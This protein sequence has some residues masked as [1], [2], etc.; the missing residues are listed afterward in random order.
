MN[1]SIG[2]RD[3]HTASEILYVNNMFSTIDKVIDML[4]QKDIPFFKFIPNPCYKF[5]PYYHF[6]RD[7]RCAKCKLYFTE[8]ELF[9]VE[10]LGHVCPDC[11]CASQDIDRCP[12]CGEAY[13]ISK[14]HKC[15]TGYKK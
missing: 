7:Y 10:G 6:D 15:I 11:L 12:N 13:L 4:S 5:S 9:P 3:E 1:L 14:Q 2:Y 8:D